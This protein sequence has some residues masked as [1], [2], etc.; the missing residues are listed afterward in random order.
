MVTMVESHTSWASGSALEQL[1]E[2]SW[3]FLVREGHR[4][5][6][7]YTFSLVSHSS[8]DAGSSLVNEMVWG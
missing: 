3:E 6:E 2:A 7:P 8:A 4:A 1:F 5:G